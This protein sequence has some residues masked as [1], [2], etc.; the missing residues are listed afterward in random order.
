M[1]EDSSTQAEALRRILV[2]AGHQVISA[3]DGVEGL[4][5]AI[6][7]DPQVIVSDISMPRM[8]GFELCQEIRKNTQT[9]HIPV[10]L[11]T[12]LSDVWDIV[13]GL[14]A[15]ADNYVTK[16]DDALLLL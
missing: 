16:P 12:A 15:G 4:S 13:R 5:L 2:N 9:Q 11:L 14:N 7:S 6:G 8:D 10:I 1:V 3:H